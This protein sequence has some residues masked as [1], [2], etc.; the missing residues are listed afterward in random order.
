MNMRRVGLGLV[1]GGLLILGGARPAAAQT[2]QIKPRV[3]IMVDTSGSM[4]YHLNADTSTG[5]DGSD[6][7]QSNVMTRSK[8]TTPGYS[9]YEGFQIQ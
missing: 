5:G 6:L 2:N 9:P 4:N 1:V 3:L 7:Y 8:A